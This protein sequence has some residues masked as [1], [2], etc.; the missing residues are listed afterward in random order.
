MLNEFKC[1][2]CDK[3]F[4]SKLA[5]GGHIGSHSRKKGYLV[6]KDFLMTCKNCDNGFV[7]TA[8]QFSKIKRQFCCRKCQGQ[9]YSK[10]NKEEEMKKIFHGY[11]KLDTDIQ[12]TKK[13]MSA[14]LNIS[15]NK[16][17]QFMDYYNIEY[18][19]KI[20]SKYVQPKSLKSNNY[21]PVKE[22]L[23]KG[24]QTHLGRLKSKLFLE[25]YKEKRCEICLNDMWNGN[26]I[27]LEL[28]H[29]DGDSLNNE[30]TNLQILCPN[31][32]AQTENYKNKNK[33]STRKR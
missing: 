21:K 13:Q 32:H 15:V 11:S 30:L 20:K 22:Y 18:Q 12:Y 3:E 17:N 23:I 14:E 4:S 19:W 29:I 2:I 26:P 6:K 25:N 8:H 16:L 31:C 5:L 24:K 27:P 28:H 1:H 7:V 33:N 9:Y 10:L